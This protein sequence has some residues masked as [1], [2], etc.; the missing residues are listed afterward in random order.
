M[1][2]NILLWIVQALLT[3]LF[4]L[5]GGM[6]LALPLEA[7]AGP[8][9]LPGWFLRFLGVC[10]VL[11]AVGLIVP[12]LTSICPALTPLAASGLVI[13]MTGATTLTAV[14]VGVA[15]ALLPLIVGTLA[16]S[17]AYGRRPSALTSPLPR[18]A[19]LQVQQ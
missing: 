1:R 8:I 7:F 5:A 15:P 10:E 18:R 6:K 19:D 12:Y 2:T 17:V 13:I 11:G 4:L 14:Y 3:A 9:H 16:A